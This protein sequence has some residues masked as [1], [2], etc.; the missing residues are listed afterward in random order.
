MA[1]LQRHPTP[2]RRVAG[3]TLVELLVVIGIIALL[4]SILLPALNKARQQANKAACLSNLHQIG[5]ATVEYVSTYKGTLPEGVE[6]LRGATWWS[7]LARQMGM[8]NQGINNIDNPTPGQIDPANG[9]AQ[10]AKDLAFAL[11]DNRLGVFR[12]R[13]AAT[14]SGGSSGL[15]NYSCHPLLMPDMGL[16]YP[17]LFPEPALVNTVRRPYRLSHIPNTY[18]IVLVFDSAQC[19]VSDL[20]P[21]VGNPPVEAGDAA[22][23][24]FNLDNNRISANGGNTNNVGETFMVTGYNNVNPGLPVDPGPNV[25]ANGDPTAGSPYRWGNIRFR[26]SG[27]KVA[28]A[29]FADGH[30]G[31]FTYK[32][33]GTTPT[34]D[35]LRRNLLVP[36]P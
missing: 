34:T 5:L 26:H 36:A 12:C 18:E 15:C 20:S 7:I 23:C 16:T 27:N 8:A 19:L 6:P 3:F 35:L 22:A 10:Q 32:M 2:S 4:I 1:T 21:T 28:N 9:S 17:A 24:G 25:E 29:L 31:S 33:A 14:P 13:D 30:A 11:N